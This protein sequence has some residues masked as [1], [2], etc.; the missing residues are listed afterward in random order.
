MILYGGERVTLTAGVPTLNTIGVSLGRIVRF[1]GHT[2]EWYSV[3][4]HSLVVAELLPPEIGVYGQMHDAQ[5]I[6]ASDVPSPM[7]TQVA[8]QRERMIQKRIYIS[9]GLQWPIPDEI[10]EAVE[11]ADHKALLAEAHILGHPGTSDYWGTEY[12][13]EAAKLTRKYLKKTALF[14]D[15]SYSGPYFEKTFK[16]F[17][18]LAGLDDPGPWRI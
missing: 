3:L 8:R 9:Y 11:V 13:A 1:T 16:K 5:E 10:V 2:K 12:D 6:C 18:K 4:S 15:P 17:A 7:K 14:L